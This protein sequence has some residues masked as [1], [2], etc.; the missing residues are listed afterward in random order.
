MQNLH[1]HESGGTLLF[2]KISKKFLNLINLVTGKAIS[3]IPSDSLLDFQFEK[4]KSFTSEDIVQCSKFSKL[5]RLVLF[6]INL[7]SSKEFSSLCNLENLEELRV[8][9]VQIDNI[10][11]ISELTQLRSLYLGIK[12][13][14]NEG[15]KSIT[16]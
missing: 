14:S 15:F 2:Q 11:G 8:H 4:S 1:L 12:E 3:H 6:S 16:R 13:L 5:R 7:T 10:E 9:S